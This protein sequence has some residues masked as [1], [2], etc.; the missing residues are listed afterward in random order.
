MSRMTEK[1]SVDAG[2]GKVGTSQLMP[3]YLYNQV[4]VFGTEIILYSSNMKGVY[5]G[6]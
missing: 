5:T 3:G 2:A 6:N 1:R 4:S